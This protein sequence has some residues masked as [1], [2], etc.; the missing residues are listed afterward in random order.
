MYVCTNSPRSLRLLSHWRPFGCSE[1]HCPEHS[2]S[3][4]CFPLL[5]VLLVFILEIIAWFKVM[6]IT[7]ASLSKSSI[8]SALTFSIA[9]LFDSICVCCEEGIWFHS[10]AYGYVVIPALFVEKQLSLERHGFELHWS[11]SMHIFF[12]RYITIMLHTRRRVEWVQACG[13]G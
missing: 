6:K 11:T 3:S 2:C 10:L 7:P 13:R 12:N 1:Q 9:I 5:L 4:S 8:V